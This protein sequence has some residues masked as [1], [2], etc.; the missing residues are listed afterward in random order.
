MQY[1]LT[2]YL[3]VVKIKSGV[4]RCQKVCACVGGGGGGGAHSH[5]DL[6]LRTFGKE[7]I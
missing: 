4:G 3:F 2:K 7:P 6:H 1:I 5:I